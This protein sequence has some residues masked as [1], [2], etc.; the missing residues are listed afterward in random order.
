MLGA[1]E[2]EEGSESKADNVE[3]TLKRDAFNR[4][5][6]QFLVCDHFPSFLKLMTGLET[7]ACCPVCRF[8]AAC[9]SARRST[10]QLN[11]LARGPTG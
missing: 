8:V 11:P 9:L 6:N 2:G 10:C 1:K 4:E 7:D 5:Y 3:F